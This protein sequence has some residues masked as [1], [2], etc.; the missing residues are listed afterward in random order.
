MRDL[1]T[2]DLLLFEDSLGGYGKYFTRVDS[3]NHHDD[4]E[5]QVLSPV[6]R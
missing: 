6:F 5:K 4:L 3:F 2:C 1:P